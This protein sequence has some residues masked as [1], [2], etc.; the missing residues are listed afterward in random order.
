MRSGD[1]EAGCREAGCSCKQM[2]WPKPL[3]YSTNIVA[4]GFLCCCIDLKHPPG[5][6]PTETLRVGADVRELLPP[7]ARVA[8]LFAFPPFMQILWV[9]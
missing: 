2:G 4:A 5:E 1:Y 8:I 6:S 9:N 3:P 7:Y